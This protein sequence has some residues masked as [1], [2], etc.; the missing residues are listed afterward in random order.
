MKSRKL[1][2]L[3]AAVRDLKVLRAAAAF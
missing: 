1:M 2:M 3:I